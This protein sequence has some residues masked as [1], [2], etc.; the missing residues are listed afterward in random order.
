[1]LRG[2]SQG[3]W[4]IQIQIPPPPLPACTRLSAILE[5]DPDFDCTFSTAK[6]WGEQWL[7]LL[8]GVPKL[9]CTCAAA[10][11]G[12]SVLPGT[13]AVSAAGS[14]SM[15]SQWLT[16]KH[17]GATLRS[18]FTGSKSGLERSASTTTTPTTGRSSPSGFRGGPPMSATMRWTGMSRTERCGQS[19]LCG[20]GGVFSQGGLG[21]AGQVKCRLS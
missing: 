16:R 20:N 17:S 15:P 10:A 3:G 19:L 21:G 5:P 6:N 8:E 18:S 1:M 9:C 11:L 4:P 14:S 7:Q 2:T 12:F 13:S